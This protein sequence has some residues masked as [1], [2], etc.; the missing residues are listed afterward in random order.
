MPRT[1]VCVVARADLPVSARGAAMGFRLSEGCTAGADIGIAL[2]GAADGSCALGV[3]VFVL[4]WEEAV[5]EPDA[6]APAVSVCAPSAAKRARL[7]D[8]SMVGIGV[9]FARGLFVSR[10][11]LAVADIGPRCPPPGWVALLLS[12]AWKVTRLPAQGGMRLWYR[13]LDNLLVPR[14]GCGIRGECCPV[15]PFRGVLV[16]VV[17]PGVGEQPQWAPL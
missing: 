11:G 3:V 6:V 16:V 17:R 4:A 10:W 15:A 1:P 13:A 12:S 2:R 9:R 7:V 5:E 14:G 8:G